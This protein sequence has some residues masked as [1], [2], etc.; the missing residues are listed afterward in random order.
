[1]LRELTILA[2]LCNSYTR[3]RQRTAVVK[4]I[5]FNKNYKETWKGV[6]GLP[7]AE[8]RE[9]RPIALSL[10]FCLVC[11]TPLRRCPSPTY[12]WLMQVIL[13]LVLSHRSLAVSICTSCCNSYR[14]YFC[15]RSVMAPYDLPAKLRLFP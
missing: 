13:L 7:D 9:A 1:M 11:L 2:L 14:V 8:S 6:E 4:F 5:I 3:T 12:C 15:P 10:S